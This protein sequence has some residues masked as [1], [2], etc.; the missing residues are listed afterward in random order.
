MITLDYLLA[1]GVTLLVTHSF[2]NIAF[3]PFRLSKQIDLSL[4]RFQQKRVD[5]KEL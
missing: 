2:T 4:V 5:H 3:L 1:L